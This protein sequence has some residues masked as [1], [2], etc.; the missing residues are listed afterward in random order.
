MLP[1]LLDSVDAAR[2]RYKGEVQVIVADNAS[3]DAT[4]AIARARGCEVAYV[5]QRRIAASRNG[6]AKLAR[7]ESLCFIDADSSIH[8]QT[9]HAIDEALARRDV[10]GGATGV[11]PERW[12]VGI[13]ATW[14]VMLPMVWVTRMDTG[15]VFCRRADFEA[16]GGYDEERELAE[17][18]AFLWA[19][20]RLGA[21]RGQ[22]LAR[23]TQT[24]AMASMRKFD[25]HG[26]W[27]YFTT[28]IPQGAPAIFRRSARTKLAQRYWYTDD[29]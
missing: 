28:V 3:T 13:V 2:A 5:E 8:P 4:A 12:S 7:A 23:L 10:V 19:L 18:V 6:G 27:H 21:R 17:D 1:R 14:M 25:R 26:D 9:F 16:L 11:Y 24:K 20:K 15:V 22:R 29:R